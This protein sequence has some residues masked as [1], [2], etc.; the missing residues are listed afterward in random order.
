MMKLQLC[1]AALLAAAALAGCA[2]LG[3]KPEVQAQP[4]ICDRQCLDGA[5]DTYLAALVAHDP[6]KAPLAAD[7]KTVE[8]AK[9]IKPA[10]GLWKAA[11]EGPTT[12]KIY[13]PDPVSQEIGFMGVM[14]EDGKPIQ[15]GM[16]L[17]LNKDGKIVEAEHMIARDLA[18]ANLANLQTPRPGLLAEVP[19]AERESRDA[20]I[21]EGAAYYDSLDDNDGSLAPFADDCERHENGMITATSKPLDPKGPKPMNK[22][23]AY[24]GHI[25]CAKQLDT[26]TM[27]YIDTIDNRRVD[28]ADPV[29]GLVLGF[30]HF[31]HSMKKQYVDV[32]G[33]PGIKRIPMK[34]KA[35]D[36]PAMHIF[37]V[38]DGKIHEIEAMGFMAPYNS[39]TGWE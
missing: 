21:K 38:Q 17:K 25:G 16:R 39:P 28:V 9:A 7:I 18:P 32:V 19:P 30:S 34:F 37:K 11:S 24:L 12:F 8:N 29:T 23:F 3:K 14:K 5:A 10:E 15:L 20:L 33:V 4:K 36:L 2:N 13:V 26:K 31:H 27:S 6:S 22:A 35:F 1:A